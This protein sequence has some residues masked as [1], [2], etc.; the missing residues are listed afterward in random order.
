MKILLTLA[1][2][3]LGWFAALFAFAALMLLWSR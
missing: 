1:G 3:A 2:L